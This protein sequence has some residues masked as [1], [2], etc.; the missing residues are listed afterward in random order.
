MCFDGLRNNSNYTTD[1]Q[2]AEQTLNLYSRGG[3]IV[4]GDKI[5][6]LAS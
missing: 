3:R 5:G 1:L 4:L 6:K 2:M